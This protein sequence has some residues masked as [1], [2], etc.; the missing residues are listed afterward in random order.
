M[1]SQ[2]RDLSHAPPSKR[3]DSVAV[4]D[5]LFITAVPT[6]RDGLRENKTCYPDAEMFHSR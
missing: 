5:C 4:C 1:I 3:S 6:V 2:R